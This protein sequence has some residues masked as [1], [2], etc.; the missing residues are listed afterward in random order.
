VYVSDV[1]VC[2][3]RKGARHFSDAIAMATASMEVRVEHLGK[4]D[5]S[6]LWSLA[7]VAST[8]RNHGRWEKAEELEVRVTET[9]RRVLGEERPDTL[10]SM[11]NLAPTYSHQERWADAEQLQIQA[12]A[13]YRKSHSLQ[14]P[15]TLTAIESPAHIRRMREHA[16]ANGAQEV[17]SSTGLQRSEDNRENMPK[18]LERSTRKSR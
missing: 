13:S 11:A 12:M 1:Q 8:C 17:S 4:E 10:A 2:V 14:H 18:V 5:E 16:L 3:V 7:M 6:T 15:H 9:S